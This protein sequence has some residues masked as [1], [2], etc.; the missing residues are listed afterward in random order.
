MTLHQA[1]ALIESAARAAYERR[2]AAKTTTWSA[3]TEEQ[4]D[5][6][7]LRIVR[8]NLYTPTSPRGPRRALAR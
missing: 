8:R 4:R 2:M 1:A 6:H 7:R 5:H 3:L